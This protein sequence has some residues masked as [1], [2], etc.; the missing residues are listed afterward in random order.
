[1]PEYQYHLTEIKVAFDKGEY[2]KS[3][4]DCANI[5]ETYLSYLLNCGYSYLTLPFKITNFRKY[6]P[7]LADIIKES[8]KLKLISE[9]EF[10]SLERLKNLRNDA[11]HDVHFQKKVELNEN[12][13]RN[14]ILSVINEAECM[15]DMFMKRAQLIGIHHFR[16]IEQAPKIIGVPFSLNTSIEQLSQIIDPSKQPIKI[17]SC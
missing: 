10:Q 2:A 4:I 16:L 13:L 14:N 15:R 6:K 7:V 3:L 11:A 5:I 12:G 17:G 9:A 8:R 1:M